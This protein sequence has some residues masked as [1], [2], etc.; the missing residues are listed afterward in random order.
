MTNHRGSLFSRGGNGAFQVRIAFINTHPIQY[1]AP[2]Y[3]ALNRTEDLSVTALY[4]SNFSVRGDADRGFG[5]EVKW[6]IDLLEG[7]EARFVR[8]ADRRG[9]P[10]SFTS[11]VVPELW[12][13]VRRGGFDAV[14][15]HGHT[16]AAMLIAA[17][18]AKKA[19]IP[20][21]LRC[22]THLG[23]RRSSIKNL[24]RRLLV[25]AYYRR[26]D[27]VLAIGSA[28][29][30]F[31]RAIGVPAR[32]IFDMPYAVDNHRFMIGA[33]LGD[34]KRTQLRAEFGVH[35]S[36]P[37]VLFAA[38]FQRRK[39][40]D[41][42]LYAAARLNR[43]GVVFH[44]AM[45]GSGEMETELRELA[46]QL[47]LSNVHFAG[48]VN[49]AALPR[50]YAACDAFV[51]PSENETWGLAINEAMCA[52]LPIVAS[53]E[54]GCVPDLVHDGCNGR[55]FPAGDITAL[56]KALQPLLTDVELRRRMGEASRE[57][58]ARWGYAECQTGLRKALASVGLGSAE[59]KG[60]RR[61]SQTSRPQLRTD[62]G[63]T[64]APRQLCTKMAIVGGF[65]GTHVGGSLWRAA[66][67]LGIDTATFDV[68]NASGSRILRAILW[69]FGDR[70]LPGMY[71]FSKSIVAACRQSGPEL[72]I[73]TG[74]APLDAG[75]LRALRAMG[76]LC[77]NYST[78]DPWNPALRA[79]WHLRGLP[80]YDAVFT[81][82]R[83]NVSGFADI[84]CGN[85][86]YLPFAYDE[87]LSCCHARSS[88]APAP[89]VLFA[90]GADRDRVEFM[91][92]FL[93]TGPRIGLVGGYWERFPAMRPYALGQ[94]A[95]EALCALTAAVKV[96]LCLVRRANRD[97]HVMRSFEIAALGGCMLAEDTAEHREIFGADGDAV[98]YFHTPREAAER[99][100]SLLADPAER[101]RLSEAVRVRILGGAHTYRDRLVSIIE[102]ATQIRR[103]RVNPDR[104]VL[105]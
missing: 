30:A 105:N 75:A 47:R 9:E 56:T 4:L 81:T 103:A 21:F 77:V 80:E 45:V 8:G 28:N 36:R 1:F 34:G 48:F 49:Q 15:V 97:G 13:E 69:R 16:P 23:L 68:G 24:L 14:V 61:G 86:Y 43:A 88:V 63:L 57:I 54:I 27:G 26:L 98:V 67:H 37:I 58:I 29:R 19:R 72:L 22:E 3:A 100:R 66:A 76:I 87:W 33:Q 73:A 39:R 89:E 44:L 17:A 93:R 52:G 59:A 53:S 51:L 18:A 65:D 10:A 31:Y 6:D 94:W 102:A 85:V 78:D 40:P 62:A 71:R 96:N 11:A 82:R 79:F 90:G 35:D 42:L 60:L 101:A 91:T 64:L 99:A 74:A 84:G 38:K 55:T 83:A 50:V 46:R 95:P 70:R 104:P 32:L 12:Q 20:T 25:G 7:Y 2:L 41:D 5:Q 92:E